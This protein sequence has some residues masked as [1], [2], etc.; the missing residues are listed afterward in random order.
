MKE[1]SRTWISRTGEGSCLPVRGTA[2]PDAGLMA[3]SVSLSRSISSCMRFIC[4]TSDASRAV[5]VRMATTA[6]PPTAIGRPPL[7]SSH[8]G[9]P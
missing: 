2:C 1:T 5:E 3:S 4:C 6:V 7:V 9:T 8:H